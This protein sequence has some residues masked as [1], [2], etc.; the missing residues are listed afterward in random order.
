MALTMLVQK[1]ALRGL[2]GLALLAMTVFGA[3]GG[4]GGAFAG[5]QSSR[6]STHVTLS[7]GAVLDIA[8]QIGID[9]ASVRSVT[10]TL[11][12]PPGVTLLGTVSAPAPAGGKPEVRLRNDAPNGQYRADAALVLAS[13]RDVVNTETVQL[14]AHS[15]S[16]IAPAGQTLSVL[17]SSP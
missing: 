16:A 6:T 5:S 15:A 11:H 12:V 1:N 13:D 8:L 2:A 7:N 4:S 9:A 14:G 10:Y 17:L 3:L